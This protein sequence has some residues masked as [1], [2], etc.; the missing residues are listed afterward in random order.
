[1][2]NV[3]EMTIDEILFELEQLAVEKAADYR[4]DRAY[5]SRMKELRDEVRRRVG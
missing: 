5:E 1:M 4:N 2:N 3:K